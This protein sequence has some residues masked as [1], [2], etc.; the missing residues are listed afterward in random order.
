MKAQSTAEYPF[1]KLFYSSDNSAFA[2]NPVGKKN[3]WKTKKTDVIHRNEQTLHC[4]S[5][6]KQN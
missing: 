3:T 5:R 1:Q 4:M 2:K 6:V